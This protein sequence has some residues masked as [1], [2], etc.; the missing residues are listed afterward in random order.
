MT[1]TLQVTVDIGDNMKD[2]NGDKIT[3]Y[4]NW[5]YYTST[6]TRDAGQA[7]GYVKCVKKPIPDR[8][9]QRR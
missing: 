5:H 2:G 9:N 6:A 3:V 1:T 7:S 8:R 4:A